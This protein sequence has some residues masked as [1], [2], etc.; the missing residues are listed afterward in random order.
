MLSSSF[1]LLR[2]AST[3]YFFDEDGAYLGKE[4][5]VTKKDGTEKIQKE[6]FFSNLIQYF[7]YLFFIALQIIY[8][9]SLGKY[10]VRK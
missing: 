1:C 3:E 10:L 8:E 6:M 7:V 4:V 9:F 2:A 5:R